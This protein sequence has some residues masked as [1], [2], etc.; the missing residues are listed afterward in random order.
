MEKGRVFSSKV[1]NVKTPD[2]QWQRW[3]S[4]E[5]PTSVDALRTTT[6]T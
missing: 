2:Q 1:V 6:A 5:K 3:C 4:E